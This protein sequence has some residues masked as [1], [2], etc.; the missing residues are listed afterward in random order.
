MC[1]N[2]K[3][4]YGY[5]LWMAKIVWL[6]ESKLNKEVWQMRF[7]P[8][9]GAEIKT[10]VWTREVYHLKQ[11]VNAF[12]TRSALR[13]V[14][15]PKHWWPV[16]ANQPRSFKS[17]EGCNKNT[18]NPIHLAVMHSP[19][20]HT[21]HHTSIPSVHPSL[22]IAIS[23]KY[24]YSIYIYIY[25]M[26]FKNDQLSGKRPAY[27]A[28]FDEIFISR[29]KHGV[30]RPRGF[31]LGD[32]TE[33]P[34]K[35][36]GAV[37]KISSAKRPSCNVERSMAARRFAGRNFKCCQVATPPIALGNIQPVPPRVSTKLGYGRGI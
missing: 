5:F 17:F 15:G 14:R 7:H 2:E 13:D 8:Q 9:V 18:A 31:P 32:H 23:F 3:R 19:S 27:E 25:M 30:M 36:T 34:I 10:P 21:F 22:E 24:E 11:H 28:T 6:R 1:G 29:V 35:S 33:S 4:I 37:A 12:S 20:I 16:Q 26:W